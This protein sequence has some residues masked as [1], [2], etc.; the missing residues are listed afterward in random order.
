MCYCT[1][2]SICFHTFYKFS[3]WTEMATVWSVNLSAMV[4][5]SVM[6]LR[7]NFNLSCLCSVLNIIYSFRCTTLSRFFSSL[8]KKVISGK[9]MSWD[10][11]TKAQFRDLESYVVPLAKSVK[12][13]QT[14]Y[15]WK[16][17]EIRFEEKISRFA[18]KLGN[19]P[20]LQIKVLCIC[21]LNIDSFSIH[22]SGQI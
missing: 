4:S 20:L 17:K 21:A 16:K 15:L 7:F 19:W 10:I 13:H 11:V 8:K 5:T 6:Q 1:L 14:V 2:R 9:Q 12:I 22:I 18:N 3:E